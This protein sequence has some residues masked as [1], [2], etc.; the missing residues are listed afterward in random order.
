MIR[1]DLISIHRDAESLFDMMCSAD[2]YL[3]SVPI[4][5]HTT[6]GFTCWLQDRLAFDFH[7]FRGIYNDDKLIGFVHNYDF[8]YRD[9]RCHVAA[10][11]KE[12]YRGSGAGVKASVSFL[13][14][15]FHTYPLRKIYTSVYSY[16]TQ[17]LLTN[18]RAGFVEEGRL[19]ES[20][21]HQGKYWD[22]VIF[23][24]TKEQFYEEFGN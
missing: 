23:S 19:L 4:S 1:L 22:T 12:E 15:L 18:Q 2:Q 20:R 13:R 5:C 10:C 6:E 14:Y 9:G 17:S 7:D 16:N 21:Y 11:I 8:S 3:F 24:V